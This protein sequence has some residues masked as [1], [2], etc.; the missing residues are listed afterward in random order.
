MKKLV[1]V[2][3]LPC[4]QP[5][6]STKKVVEQGEFDEL[7]VLVDNEAA[8][9]NVQRFL[10]KSGFQGIAVEPIGKDYRI[11]VQKSVNA[12]IPDVINESYSCSSGIAK[13]VFFLNATI[14]QGNEELGSKLLSAFIYTLTERKENP[15]YLLFMNNGVKLCIESSSTLENLQL[16]EKSGVQLLVC[17]T[18]LNYL[19]VND[20][21]RVG[22]V[23]NMYDIAEVLLTKSI[24]TI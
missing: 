1:D 2:R 9:D 12:I 8:R 11:S 13:C 20:Q 24:L 17:G 15:E 23:S 4:P 3:G 16:L 6:L 18:C 10:Q 14:G 19:G 21:L 5:V 7:T 22:K